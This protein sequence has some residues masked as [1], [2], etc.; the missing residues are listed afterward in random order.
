[1]TDL[2]GI[3]DRQFSMLGGSA[4]APQSHARGH[5]GVGHGAAACAGLSQSAS[6]R[7]RGMAASEEAETETSGAS[8]GDSLSV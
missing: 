2:N 8:E 6:V 5:V 4:A 7:Y 3:C 1:V